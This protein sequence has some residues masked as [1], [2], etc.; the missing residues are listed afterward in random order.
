MQLRCSCGVFPA[1]EMMSTMKLNVQWLDFVK[2]QP[3][4]VPM[5]RSGLLARF[6]VERAEHRCPSCNSP[7]YSRRHQ[8]CGICGDKLPMECQFTLAEAGRVDAL[9]RLERERHRQWLRRTAAA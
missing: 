7:V 1:I 4:S 6:G 9:M 2:E 5:V 3:V 8:I